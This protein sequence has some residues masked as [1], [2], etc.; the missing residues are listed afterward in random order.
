[1]E[2]SLLSELAS[3][4]H[5]LNLRNAVINS[6]R[7]RLIADR[8]LAFL[9]SGGVDSSLVCAVAREAAQRAEQPVPACWTVAESEE[10]PDFSSESNIGESFR[11]L[12][13]KID[14]ALYNLRQL[15]IG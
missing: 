4:N 9:L 5:L 3:K 10:N 2:I 13:R 15:E 6:V 12:K 11:K 8:P 7:R 14:E 1:M